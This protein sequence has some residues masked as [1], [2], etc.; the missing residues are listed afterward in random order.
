[1]AHSLNRQFGQSGIYSHLNTLYHFADNHDV[2]RIASQLNDQSHLYPLYAL[3]F[4]L[5]GLSSV[6]YGSEFG[7]EAHKQ[8][9]DWNLRPA[10]DLPRLQ[11][12][13]HGNDLRAW[14]SRLALIRQNS[15]ALKYGTYQTLHTA[16]KQLAFLR[17]E[18]D[19]RVIVLV[20]SATE[21]VQIDLQLPG[22]GGWRFT[23]QLNN[24]QTYISQSDGQ[25]KLSLFPRT[26]LFLL[27]TEYR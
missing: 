24:G 2:S 20:N 13:Q 14:I 3:L 15:P 25:L 5:P 16:A 21:E 19:S 18:G 27:V 6:Y 8:S 11:E 26:A 10:F 9:D 1:L 17:T 7:F 4:S 23:D 12:E 22:M